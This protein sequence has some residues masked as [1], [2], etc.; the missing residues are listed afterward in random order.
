MLPVWQ[1]GAIGH[2]HLQNYFLQKYSTPVSSSG[3]KDYNSMS[4]SRR[5]TLIQ[6]L[7][8][9][10][11]KL[12]FKV[13][14]TEW[15]SYYDEESNN[16][17]RQSTQSKENIVSE[18]CGLTRAKK[19]LDIGAN[20]GK[21]SR[22]AAKTCD[23]VISAD[24][25]V[26]AINNN[27]RKSIKLQE[28]NLQV[29]YLDVMHPTPAI[30]WLNEERQSFLQRADFDLVIALALI[31]HLVI[32]EGVPLEKVCDLFC[33]LTKKYLIIEIP[34]V[35]DSQIEI[36]QKWGGENSHLYS[37]ADFESTFEKYFII[38]E[39]RRVKESERNIYL[40]EKI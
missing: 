22:I 5:K 34:N 6:S 36:L 13:K 3:D 12:S 28:R 33:K 7:Y 23:L 32:T 9:C 14:K 1:R 2:I 30:G 27:Y 31:H 18:L 39:I 35:N 38:K 24:Y 26:M 37:L 21:Y 15:G 40:L 16:Y 25:D 10:V 4:L 20:L 11:K 8:E 29:I 17:L 19:A